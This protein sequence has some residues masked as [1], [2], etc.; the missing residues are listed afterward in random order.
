MTEAR[1]SAK[2][3][4]WRQSIVWGIAYREIDKDTVDEEIA[5]CREMSK[6]WDLSP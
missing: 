4:I 3:Y 2:R 1:T 6:P 5:E